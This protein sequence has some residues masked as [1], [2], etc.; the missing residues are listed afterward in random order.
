MKS[1]IY[2]T[3]D[4][5]GNAVGELQIL[6]T[7][8]WPE[9]RHLTKQDYLIVAGDFGCIFHNENSPRYKEE[10]NWLD[11]LSKK[12]W[13]TL[14]IDGNHENFDRLNAYTEVDMFGSK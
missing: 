1:R 7:K 2:I 3:G 11:W 10:Q 9:G 12:K 8:K 14:F 13:T 5:H 6:G 4:T